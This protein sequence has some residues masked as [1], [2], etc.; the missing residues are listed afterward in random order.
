MA[1]P[2]EQVIGVREDDVCVEFAVQIALQDAFDGGLGPDRH[3]D[4]SFHNAVRGVE[5]SRA[6]AGVGTLGL[7][8]ETHNLTVMGGAGPCPLALT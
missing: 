5:Q 2:Q 3:E 4:R 7:K 1:G 8:F 6:G